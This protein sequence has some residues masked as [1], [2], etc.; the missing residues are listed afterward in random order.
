MTT[1]K[2]HEMLKQNPADPTLKERVGNLL[3]RR[4]EAAGAHELYA[5]LRA[6]FDV[7]AG[8][9]REFLPPDGAAAQR[10][11]AEGFILDEDRFL[12]LARTAYRSYKP[13]T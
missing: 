2:I 13:E 5:Y 11:A 10:A 6:L 8:A 4:T 1:D 9:W 3:D 12:D 7:A